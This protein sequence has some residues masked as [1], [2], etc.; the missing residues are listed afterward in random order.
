MLI[1]AL[2]TTASLVTAGAVA[3]YLGMLNFSHSQDTLPRTP[4]NETG[5]L[6]ASLPPTL[7]QI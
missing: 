5:V 1:A 2:V 7:H 4:S 6:L 3:W